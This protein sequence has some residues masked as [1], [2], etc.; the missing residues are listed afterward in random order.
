MLDGCVNFDSQLLLAK[1]I[2]KWE[3]LI[4]DNIRKYQQ[5]LLLIISCISIG[6]LLMSTFPYVRCVLETQRIGGRRK[7]QMLQY[8]YNLVPCSQYTSGRGSSAVGLTAYVTKDPEKKQ[9]VLQT[10]FDSK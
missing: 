2:K 5:L 4:H 10:K 8:V 1:I 9:L 3:I 7:S 6:I